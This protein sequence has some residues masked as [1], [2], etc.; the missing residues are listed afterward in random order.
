MVGKVRRRDRKYLASGR[1]FGR[2][3]DDCVSDLFLGQ[4]ALRDPQSRHVKLKVVQNRDVA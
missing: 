3:C 2:L 1:S 4:T